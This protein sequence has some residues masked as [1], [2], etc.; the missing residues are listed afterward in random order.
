MSKIKKETSKLMQTSFYGDELV[1]DTTKEMTEYDIARSF[2]WY[3]Y[4]CDNSHARKYY[5]AI[6]RPAEQEKLKAVPDNR[7]NLTGAWLA[8]L[9][10]LGANLPT[11]SREFLQRKID[12]TL[13]YSLKVVEKE[14]GVY[15]PN[16]QERIREKNSE[17]VGELLGAIDD[18]LPKNWSCYDYLKK[19]NATPLQAAAVANR[20]SGQAIELAEALTTSDAQLKSAY[21][22]YK[23]KELEALAKLYAG[24]VIDA[25]RYADTNKKIRAPR[26]KKAPS[27]E[28]LLKTFKY[29]KGID[30]YKIASI[31]PSKVL[32]AQEL[33]MFN[34][35]NNLLTVLKANDRAGL[36]IKGTTIVNYD[37]KTSYCKTI[38]R[39]TQET[40][41]AVLGSGKVA[42]RKLQ[43]NKS[44]PVTTT[45]TNE[46]TVLLKVE[47]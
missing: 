38:G 17:F 42:L 4:N 40:I 2:N 24:I 25:D 39:K 33:Y 30:R 3:A 45:R 14:E 22:A 8:R 31:A 21:K 26:K 35:K 23:P 5:K 19:N 18:G 27:V 1:P 16:I 15:K 10:A 44:K 20:L 9:V 47:K 34:A 37:T 36:S 6:L 11:R 13:S 7:L 43:D 32:G 41:D 12:E 46:S 28:K 29:S